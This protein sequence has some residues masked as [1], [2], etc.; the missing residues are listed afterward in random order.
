MKNKSLFRLV[1]VV[2]ALH[3][4]VLS[5]V[6]GLHHIGYILAATLIAILIGGV[7]RATLRACYRGHARN[8]D[9]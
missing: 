5:L 6:F 1:A 8:Q 9:K 3:V 7:V 2:A 4:A